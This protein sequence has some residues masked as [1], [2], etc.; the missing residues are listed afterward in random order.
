MRERE[1][2]QAVPFSKNLASAV[3]ELVELFQWL[4]ESASRDV[5]R[6]PATARAVR[7]ELADVLI[8]FVRLA[9]RCSASTS[10]KRCAASSHQRAPLPRGRSRGNSRKAPR[11]G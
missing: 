5:A 9:A 4:T 8:Y 2:E 10:T 6:N 11:E 1:W 7:D 3:G